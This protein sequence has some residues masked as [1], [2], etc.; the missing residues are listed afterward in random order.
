MSTERKGSI[1]A[2]RLVAY[3]ATLP[4]GHILAAKALPQFGERAT[5]T[6]L[7]SH[8][9]RHG[10][11]LRVGRGLYVLPAQGRFGERTPTVEGHRMLLGAL[12]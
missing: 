11:F 1:L 3:A 7:L 10:R 6:R 4:E 12:A 5:V 8:L 2:D 9:A